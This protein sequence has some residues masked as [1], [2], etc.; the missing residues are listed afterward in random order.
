MKEGKGC[1]FV[2][3]FIAGGMVAI[4]TSPADVIKTRVMNMD[5]KKPAYTGMIDCF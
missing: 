5:V 2:S 1:H 3:S 4:V